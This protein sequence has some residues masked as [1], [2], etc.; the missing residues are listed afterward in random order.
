FTSERHSPPQISD[1]AD[2]Y[3][4]DRLQ[5]LPGVSSARIFGERR[6][7]MRI[8]LDPDRLAALDL[9][10]LDVE[11]ALRSQNVEIPAGRIES[12]NREFSV[13]SKT[14]LTTPAE[15]DALV[16][17]RVGDY[18]VRLAHVG[19]AGIGQVGSR[20]VVRFH[21]QRAFGL[22]VIK[23]ATANP[24]EVANAVKEALPAISASM[25]EGMQAHIAFD[26]TLF[27]DESI[28]NVYKT[29]VEA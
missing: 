23:Q 13:L 12:T 27:I 18:V 6:Y 1:Y 17:R 15:F 24:L 29:I 20:R 3:V 26:S 22:G 14:G 10:P 21:G 2:R 11:V 5:I 7:S 16:L 19:H 9:T 8:W 4:T 25:P 28:K